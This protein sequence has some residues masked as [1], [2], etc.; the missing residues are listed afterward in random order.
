EGR[1]LRS[2]HELAGASPARD[3][4]LRDDMDVPS[5]NATDVAGRDD[6]DA[7]HPVDL[8]RAAVASHQA[9]VLPSGSA[10]MPANGRVFHVVRLFWEEPH[11]DYRQRAAGAFP[12]FVPRSAGAGIGRGA[13]APAAGRSAAL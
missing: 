1:N 8:T 4:S 2:R 13:A 12:S 7:F 9:R 11:A 5:R 10:N 6:M 3:L